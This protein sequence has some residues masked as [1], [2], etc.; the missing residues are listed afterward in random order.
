MAELIGWVIA[1]GAFVGALVVVW[2]HTVPAVVRGLRWA[3]REV[4]DRARQRRALAIMPAELAKATAELAAV[5]VQLHVLTG[6]FLAYVVEDEQRSRGER[7]RLVQ[8]ASDLD[9]AHDRLRAHHVR[10]A[11]LEAQHPHPEDDDDQAA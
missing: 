1:A 10:L 11:V 4:R 7:S 3:R 8:L 9:A 2:R 5:G 6:H